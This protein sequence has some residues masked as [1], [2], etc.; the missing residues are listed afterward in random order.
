MNALIGYLLLHG[1]QRTLLTLC[2]FFVAMLL[3]L[4]V[5]DHGLHNLHKDAY[6][7]LGRWLL[8]GAVL[9]GCGIGVAME[10]PAVG[11]ALLQAFLAGAV[12][13]NVLKE[14]LAEERLAVRGGR[15]GLRRPPSATLTTFIS[16]QKQDGETSF[17]SS[18][19]AE[20]LKLIRTIALWIVEN[21][22]GNT[23]RRE[24]S[25]AIASVAPLS[26]ASSVR[27][28]GTDRLRHR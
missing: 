7:N 15:H 6:D 26:L 19:Y 1:P 8:A 21:E 27:G 11:P 3:K 9:L 20:R 23:R 10:L 13:L 25:Q 2:L 5:N 24:F 12:I 16:T 22:E 17:C 4:V 14:E 28:S 18:T